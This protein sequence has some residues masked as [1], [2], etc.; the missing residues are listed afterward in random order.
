MG[1]TE[2]SP[3]QAVYQGMR[4]WLMETGMRLQSTDLTDPKAGGSVRTSLR[5]L[6]RVE[7]AMARAEEEMVFPMLLEK[8]PYLVCHFER[9]HHRIA[10][11]RDEVS[12]A[13]LASRHFPSTDQVAGLRL[14]YTS[15]MAFV[16]Q[17]GLREERI[18]AGLA[19][20]GVKEGGVLVAA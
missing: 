16:L 20:A 9:E 2:H 17:H 7:A 15:Y 11:M 1:H 14:A 10:G 12:R 3:I 8:A 18:L 4:A 13:E 6:L 19:S 5:E